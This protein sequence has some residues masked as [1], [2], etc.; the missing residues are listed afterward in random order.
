ML[1]RSA[2]H[3]LLIHGLCHYYQLESRT[4]S[5]S[6]DSF[7][8]DIKKLENQQYSSLPKRVVEQIR[9]RNSLT[10]ITQE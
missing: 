3:R 8:T 5:A 10:E 1:R 4:K 7:V 6:G 2:Y 9:G